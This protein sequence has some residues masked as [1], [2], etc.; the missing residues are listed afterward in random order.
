MIAIFS[1]LFHVIMLAEGKNYS[2]ITGFYWTLT[3]MSTLG[4]GDITFSSDLGKIFSIIVMMCGVVFL[5]IMLP[6]TFIEF[7]YAPWLHAMSKFRTPREVPEDYDNHVILINVTPVTVNLSKKLKSH[8][9]KFVF[10]CG[11][12][13]KAKE[14]FDQGM[15]V[16]YGDL[17]DV[18]TFKNLR[19]EQCALVVAAENDMLN[20]KVVLTIQE[21]SE[22]IKI[23]TTVLKTHSLDILQMAGAH[24]S[25][26]LVKMFGESLARKTLGISFGTN[27]IWKLDELI[28]AEAI[29]MHSP[30]EGKTLGQIRLRETIGITVVGI[31]EK[32][33]VMSPHTDY[34]I[35]STSVLM[36]AGND[37]SIRRY[38]SLYSIPQEVHVEEAPVLILGG[39]KVGRAA[40]RELKKHHIKFSIV[41]INREHMLDEFTYIE[42]DA[43]DRNALISAGIE[44]AR[45]VLITSHDDSLN[46]YLT[47][48]CR[49][50]QP[51]IQIISRSTHERNVK[52]L[53]RAGAD[54]VMSF[55]SMGANKILN[56]LHPEEHLMEV[57][58][59]SAFKI[60]V[61]NSLVG[62]PLFQSKIR[63][64]THCSVVAIQ[65]NGKQTLNPDPFD[66]LLGTDELIIIGTNESEELFKKTFE[67]GSEEEKV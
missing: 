53:H 4:F 56:V 64:K 29:A 11:D 25:F 41:E 51:N 39:G 15:N 28:I 50:L 59:L 63:E 35:R 30:L 44:K 36:L 38:E 19:I 49:K 13:E 40:A 33:E 48:Y 6:F 10:L 21:I 57:E 23:A 62:V 5:L 67:I 34:K 46:L 9:K 26:E 54:I 47:L 55:A 61:P 43:A 3:V 20:T 45:S 16:V 8:D 65:R 7:F 52:K 58:G 24:Y 1:V 37:L 22:D 18:E 27:V 2:W 60:N 66:P 17:G 31:W 12:S 14:Y 42:G 32:G